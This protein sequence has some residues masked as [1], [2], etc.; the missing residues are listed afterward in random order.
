MGDDFHGLIRACAAA[1]ADDTVRLV[2]A[3]FLD[4]RGEAAWAR[5]IR[6]QIELHPHRGDYAR[7]GVIALEREEAALLGRAR[8]WLA[9]LGVR[10]LGGRQRVTFSRG[11]PWKLRLP[12]HQ[13]LGDGP[14]LLAELPTVDAL[15]LVMQTPTVGRTELPV[16]RQ[17]R[18]LELSG[19]LHA[20]TW[21]DNPHFAG[22]FPELTS[23]RTN[24]FFE[25]ADDLNLFAL[26]APAGLRD[27]GLVDYTGLW[28]EVAESESVR[29]S[30]S[31][32]EYRAAAPQWS[33]DWVRP[34]LGPW[35]HGDDFARDTLHGLP[36]SGPGRFERHDMQTAFVSWLPQHLARYADGE[37]GPAPIPHA[38]RA[39][40][41]QL[42][43]WWDSGQC[44][45]T[46]EDLGNP[47]DTD[48]SEADFT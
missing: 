23:I 39:L 32:S 12:L 21:L 11:L 45:V 43:D 2:L 38:R 31:L 15:A 20:L 5:F 26:R 37:T 40:A 6:V 35:D 18:H 25:S 48:D 9:Q 34:Y 22:A 29:G 30:P 42:L 3:D 44:V 41:E 28:E 19:W 46:V 8:A 13:F 4:D 47:Y 24:T 36:Y 7:P 10:K 1:P 17:V 16:A 27:F 14:R 33:F